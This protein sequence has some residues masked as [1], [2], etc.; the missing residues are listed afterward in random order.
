MENNQ[1][2]ALN[3]L[4]VLDESPASSD[5]SGCAVFSGGINVEKN[6]ICN[7]ICTDFIQTDI[8][9]VFDTLVV[10]K[11]IKVD[12]SVLPI[13]TC[14]FSNLGSNSNKWNKLF[15]VESNIQNLNTINGIIKNLKI[16]NIK[17][18][19]TCI[20]LLN[21]NI[22][23]S[24]NINLD[25]NI[26]Y[27]N[28]DQ[29][30]NN[31]IILNVPNPEIL[32]ENHKI[33]Y[34]QISN[35]PV[36]WNIPNNPIFTS[37]SNNQII[38]LI[39]VEINKWKIINYIND[40]TNVLSNIDL[41]INN[42]KSNIVSINNTI[43]NQELS[44]NQLSGKVDFLINLGNINIDISTSL[45]EQLIDDNINISQRQDNIDCSINDIVENVEMNNN[46]IVRLL[47]AVK[48]INDEMCSFKLTT[49]DKF[50]KIN[51]HIDNT[52]DNIKCIETEIIEMNIKIDLMMEYLNL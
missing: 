23:I 14:N 8:L 22:D 42:I 48:D 32:Y 7:E 24:Y 51:K 17:I 31:N 1:D 50:K 47:N 20:T 39:C 28:S 44:I 36:Q 12:G 15:A 11:N 3:R 45:I 25:T 6:I 5:K 4:N 9:K 43:C 35:C 52:D 18:M 37:N 2:Y 30:S 46:K 29:I 16:E 13:E 27:I 19:T 10:Q 26:I 38:E 40:Y 49:N 33:V 41:S 34:K 21:N